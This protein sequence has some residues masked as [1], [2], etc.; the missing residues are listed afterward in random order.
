MRFIGLFPIHYSN[1]Y[2][3][4]LRGDGDES[5]SNY[6]QLLQ[7]RGE[8]DP[9]VLEWLKCRNEKYTCSES[10]DEMLQIMALS[11]L[12]DLVHRIKSSVF[13]SIMTDETADASNREQIVIVI[14]HVSDDLVPHEE[15]TGLAKVPSIDANTVT[16]TTEDSLLRMN[17]SL[18]NCRG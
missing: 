3:L 11:I 15:F 10:Q 8:D 14:R 2:G 1:I 6:I 9:K 18:K 4:A 7:L 12:R 17:L 5:D 13:Y 16:E